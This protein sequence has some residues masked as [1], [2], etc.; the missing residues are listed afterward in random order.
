VPKDLFKSKLAIDV[1]LFTYLECCLPL[2]S[3]LNEVPKPRRDLNSE[4][5]VP[6][7]GCDDLFCQ[8]ARQCFLCIRYNLIWVLS[9]D[10]VLF[11]LTILFRKMIFRKILFYVQ[12]KLMANPWPDVGFD[13]KRFDKT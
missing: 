6:P 8:A 1:P 7:D 9:T 13:V 5:G 10:N 11:C 3:A 4:P 2:P 12:K